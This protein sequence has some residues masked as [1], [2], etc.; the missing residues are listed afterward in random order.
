MR[1]ISTAMQDFLFSTDDGGVPAVQAYGN[2]QTISLLGKHTV[3]AYT[4]ILA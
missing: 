1:G 2:S 3:Y 4:S